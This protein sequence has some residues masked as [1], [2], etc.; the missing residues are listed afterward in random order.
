M[1]FSEDDLKKALRPEDPGPAFTQR[2]M[3]GVH[4]LKAR[5]KQEDV[6]EKNG[7]AASRR[8]RQWPRW[9]QW[10][11]V[12]PA[13]ASAMAAVVLLVGLG[14]GY[15][16]YRHIEQRK[17]LARA[18]ELKRAKEAEEKVMLALRITNSKMNHVFKRVSEQMQ[19]EQG[20][21]IRRQAL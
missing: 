14:L 17:E 4:Q 3:A 8:K 12:R 18:T 10:L 21:K 9:L 13:L 19:E 20:Q 16:E 11:S 2:V 1:H 5:Q 7:A 15:R 6:L